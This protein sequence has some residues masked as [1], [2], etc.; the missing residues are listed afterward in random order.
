MKGLWA[1]YRKELYSLFASP[2]FYVVAFIF[3]VIAGYFFYSAIA[4]FNIL[5]FQASQNPFMAEQLS[6]TDMVLRPFLL[7]LSI[8]LLLVS[9]LL[10]MR[11]YAEERKTGTL[12]LLFT[13]PLTDRATLLA[14]FLALLTVFLVILFGTLP[15]TVIVAHLAKSSWKVILCGYFG[16]FLLGSAFMSLGLFT[17]SLTQ[18]QIIAAVLSFGILLMFWIIGW[19][20]SFVGST[21]AG[22]M[23]YLSIMEHFESFSKG[24]LD[25]RDLLFYIFFIVF[26]LFLTQRQIES[27]RWRG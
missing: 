8:I 24:I 3:L 25:F 18:N 2:I 9:P 27:Y 12:E 10:T 13:Y 6:F 1:V 7:D 4:Y 11:L 26:F 19:M 20:K 16:F 22:L 14:K 5:S 15:G 21:V 17:S 23:D